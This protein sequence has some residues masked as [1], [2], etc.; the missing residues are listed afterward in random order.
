MEAFLKDERPMT[1]TE[2]FDFFICISFPLFHP[3]IHIHSQRRR[4]TERLRDL[5]SDFVVLGL[6]ADGVLWVC[7]GC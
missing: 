7:L 1:G 3:L 4:F 2:Q 5:R 6:G